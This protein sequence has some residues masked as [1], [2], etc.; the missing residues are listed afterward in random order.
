MKNVDAS[1]VKEDHSNADV[2]RWDLPLIKKS[3][4][5]RTKTVPGLV[6]IVRRRQGG[7]RLRLG[8]E[9]HLL[10]GEDHENQEELS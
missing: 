5:S 2:M 9:R 3:N 10:C 1:E 4:G 6:E 7:V 8:S